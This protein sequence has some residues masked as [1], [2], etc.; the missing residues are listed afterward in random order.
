MLK[1]LPRCSSPAWT[2]INVSL[3]LFLRYSRPVAKKCRL[4]GIGQNKK[5]YK[6]KRIQITW[7]PKTTINK[8][9]F[10]LMQL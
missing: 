8:K 4:F 5:K 9:E 7:I 3:C 2:D 6:Q 1:L 10:R